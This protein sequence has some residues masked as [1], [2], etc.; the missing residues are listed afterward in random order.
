MLQ[1]CS[2]VVMVTI[3]MM[4]GM[5]M[6]TPMELLN[7]HGSPQVGY[8]VQLGLGSPYKVVSVV[9]TL[10]NTNFSQSNCSSAF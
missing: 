5:A 2:V 10:M 3:V 6:S 9:V 1:S 7:L 8:Y 4:V